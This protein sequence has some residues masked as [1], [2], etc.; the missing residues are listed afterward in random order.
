MINEGLGGMCRVGCESWCGLGL[1]AAWWTV[2]GW[3]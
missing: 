3:V 2:W 1:D